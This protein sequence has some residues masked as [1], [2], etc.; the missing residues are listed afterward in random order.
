MKNANKNPFLFVLN[1]I[2][3]PVSVC[4]ECQDAMRGGTRNS[5]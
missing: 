5:K 2:L 3:T 1:R 4:I